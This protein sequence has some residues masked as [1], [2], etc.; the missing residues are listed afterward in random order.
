MSLNFEKCLSLTLGRRWPLHIT[1]LTHLCTL[2]GS[3]ENWTYRSGHLQLARGLCTLELLVEV[4]HT[5]QL[6]LVQELSG[7]EEG[8]KEVETTVWPAHAAGL[9][10]AQ[11]SSG[12]RV[13][14]RKVVSEAYLEDGVAR[15]RLEQHQH[16]AQI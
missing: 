3:R 9:R 8:G 6:A 10:S 1:R 12:G 15:R 5:L 14:L 2:T 4:I 7:G 16:S 13:A 11:M